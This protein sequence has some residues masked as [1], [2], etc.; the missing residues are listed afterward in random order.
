MIA[1]VELVAGV[2]LLV[3]TWLS[4]LRT[5]FI[6]RQR[7]S[8]LM[9][10]V[11]YTVQRC[12]SAIAAVL[13]AGAGERVLDLCAPLALMLAG[14]CWTAATL[15]GFAL[16]T[17]LLA[18]IPVGPASIVGFMVPHGGSPDALLAVLGWLLVLVMV[19]LVLLHL[20]RITT[21]YSR[22]ETAVARLSLAS[23]RSAKAEFFLAGHLRSGSWEHLDDM[24]THWA[25]WLADIGATHTGYPALTWMRPAGEPCWLDAAVM[26]LDAA[27]LTEAVAPAWAPPSVRSVLEAG[28]HCMPALARQLG[29]DLPRPAISLQG[30]EESD[31]EHTVRL[32]VAAGLPHQRDYFDAWSEFQ[33]WRTCY[34][35]YVS[36][37]RTKMRY[38]S[39]DDESGRDPA[40][41][42]A[43]EFGKPSRTTFARSD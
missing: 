7:S 9:R 39:A 42:P 2:A 8:R 1:V 41:C 34:A 38:H 12:G 17:P 16:L 15:T 32:I 24:F 26:V 35:P 25:D 4:T 10:G 30:R 13:P 23:A 6:P 29:I 33:R 22:R 36:A 28:T 27:A 5:V 11:V 19:G 37:M 3:A 43:G 31:F 14:A 21:A 40:N 18:G 20:M